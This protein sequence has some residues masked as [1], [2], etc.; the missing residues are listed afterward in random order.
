MDISSML[1]DTSNMAKE[2]DDDGDKVKVSKE[3][4]NMFSKMG[5]N[6]LA[7]EI[8]YRLDNPVKPELFDFITSD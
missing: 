4:T 6:D 7:F 1:Q 5:S 3:L 8:N 2:K